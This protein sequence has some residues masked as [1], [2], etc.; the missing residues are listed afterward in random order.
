MRTVLRLLIA[1]PGLAVLAYVG[2][3]AIALGPHLDEL[4]LAAVLR[5]YHHI[6]EPAEVRG[7][8]LRAAQGSDDRLYLVTIQSERIVP[9]RP[10]PRGT[11]LRP[12]AF[13]HVDVWALAADTGRPVWRRRLRSFEDQQPLSA[14]IL[15]ADGETL[16]LF[17]REP[18]AVSLGD[19]RVLADGPSIEA[20]NAH[21]SGKRV[22][23]PGW[24]AFGGQGLQITLD[25]STQWVVDGADFQARPRAEAASGRSGLIGVAPRASY[26]HSFQL[27]GLSLDTRWLG[28]LTDDEAE[29]L[30]Q[31]PVVPGAR[32]G[33]P[34]GAM[35]D[36]LESQHVPGDLTPQPKP[37]RLWSAHVA[38][39]SA[40]PRDWPKSL[41]DRWGTRDR[42]SAYEPLPEA[43]AFLQAGLLG[44]GHS[45]RPFWFR[46][47]DSVLVL[48]HDKVGG[49]GRLRLT[50]IA[51]PG[52]R[53]VW[54]LLL[55]LG[56]LEAST[57][58]DGVLTLLGRLRNPEHDPRRETSRE[59]HEIIAAVDV[60]SGALSSFDLTAESRRDFGHAAATL[61]PGSRG[62]RRG[63]ARTGTP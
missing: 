43:P 56:R 45:S 42:F 6:I 13:R 59:E 32:P 25:D 2:Y 55:P 3:L 7:A 51:G 21:L 12:R 20:R 8:P 57:G 33:E 50:R 16:W 40:A 53:V 15:G 30:R 27:R 1:L 48:H 52:G 61:T 35:A 28:V 38:K 11:P 62:G 46:E 58:R 24:V 17:V 9:L 10:P 39:V 37:Y 26:T 44:D 60:R 29:V 63:R 54:D 36:L 49:A 23:R 4:D 14:E 41:P 5:G 22:D 31:P 18:V 47:P 19:G 34:R